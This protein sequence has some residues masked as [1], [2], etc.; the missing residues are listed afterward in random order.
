MLPE[1]AP[2]WID[3]A[4]IAQDL[5]ERAKLL[6]FDGLSEESLAELADQLATNAA[7]AILADYEARLGVDV[8]WAR[9]RI[10]EVQS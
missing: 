2:C 9:K 5:N 3:Y 8:T 7:D 4:F 10:R 1:Q 6:G